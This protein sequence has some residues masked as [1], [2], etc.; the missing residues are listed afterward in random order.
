MSIFFSSPSFTGCS[1]V[2]FPIKPFGPGFESQSRSSSWLSL[3][4]PG[5]ESR[6]GVPCSIPD[7]VCFFTKFNRV[8]LGSIPDQAFWHWV[9]IP[10][11]GSMF[12]SRS[13]LLALGSNPGWAPC[14]IPDHVF[15]SQSLTGCLWVRFPI[16][17][18]FHKV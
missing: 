16:E 11:G 2:R 5:F 7:R 12:D 8:S 10:V 9:R 18:V 1:W 6:L 4:G 17:F 3:F 14:S 13:S 15:C